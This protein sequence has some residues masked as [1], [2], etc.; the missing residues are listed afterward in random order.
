MLSFRR[1]L[2]LIVGLSLLPGLWLAYQ[3]I[4]TEDSSERATLLMD[5]LAL[6]EQAAYEGIDAFA[7]AQRYR[8]AGLNGI[9][10]YEETLETLARAGKIA[11]LQS[12]AARAES[13]G[14]PNLPPNS[15]LARELEPG[16]LTDAL[17]KNRPPPS[18][19]RFAGRSW[20]VF[21][22]PN[23]VE[24]EGSQRPAGPDREKVRRY[25]EEGWDIAYRPV[26]YPNLAWVGQDFPAGGTAGYLI[27]EGLEV[28]GNPDRLS[29]TVAASQ[30][31]LTGIIE[32]T[33]QTGMSAI[34]QKVPLARTFS[35]SQ[36]WLNTLDP[37]TVA[38]KYL[39][40][41]DERGARLLYLRPY[42]NE[43]MGDMTANTEALVRAVNVGLG[44][45][46]FTIG[47]VQ[48][49]SYSSPLPLRL[50]AGIGILAGVGLLA[51]LYPGFWGM[52]VAF[53]VLG[54]GVL[55]GGFTWDAL[56]LAAA[57][58]F[59]VLG[60][61]VLPERLGSLFGAVGL[62]L[63]GAVLLAAV[64]SDRNT[65]LA[66]TPFVGVAA[67]L[68]VPPALYALWVMLREH[69]PAAWVQ[70]LWQQPIRLGDVF[71]VL[72]GLAALTMLLLR[73]GN[74][75]VIGASD[76]ELSVRSLLSDYFAR[77]RFKELIG[78]P[79]AVLALLNPRWPRLLRGV[80]LTVGVVAL[81][82]IVN[83]FSHYH[84]PLL[85]S[86]E[87]T[88]VALVLGL[89]LGLVLNPIVRWGVRVVS[90]WLRHAKTGETP[91]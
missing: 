8:E 89:V 34:I 24:R 91:S 56:A 84:T 40:A 74:F 42:T 54:L 4:T 6:Q 38:D 44:A 46:G 22:E 15:L 35:I 83:S 12:T 66:V 87:R 30:D 71:L 68:V 60:Y 31:Y 7:L 26:N 2:W 80:L 64:G 76:L 90:R 36:E 62:S 59:P 17:A 28:A 73:R 61:A 53:G 10:L 86:L 1:V 32:G 49:L 47:P 52:L 81:S 18:Q 39:L 50:L 41:A 14:E 55:A 72:A 5:E 23:P 67:T 77:P 51:T 37:Q 79:L 20:Y 33:V 48:A 27:Y 69:S 75:P 82:S 57:L 78:H 21:S 16:A 25:R 29:Q 58:S 13:A 43:T 70:K 88:V 11:L 45:D 3:R 63:C 65:L 19:V 9:A 85:I